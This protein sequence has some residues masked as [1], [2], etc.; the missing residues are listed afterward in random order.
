[1]VRN[2]SA[3]STPN[4]FGEAII[5]AI[6]RISRETV[7]R[8][9]TRLRWATVTSLNPLRIRYDQEA[10]SS[11]V[12]P[13][14]L[15]KGLSVGERVRVAWFKGQATI[16]GPS[17]GHRGIGNN[18]HFLRI[19]YD[20]FPRLWT[21]VE[22]VFGREYTG[23]NPDGSSNRLM[24]VTPAGTFGAFTGTIH[25]N[26]LPYR[27][28]VGRVNISPTANTPSSVAVTFPSGRFTEPPTVVTTPGS[29][30]PGTTVTGTA[31]TG[32]SASG[33]SAWVTRTNTT[34]TTVLWVAIQA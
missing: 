1:M 15:A 30:V 5:E 23:N 24:A 26:Y 9:G 6:K 21:D 13:V 22:L 8:E 17:G 29:T 14:N 11:P 27:I 31:A 34:T 2:I 16:V 18:D 4:P 25:R 3:S 28:A 12:S 20:E 7:Q 33:F 19:G 10:E 32:I